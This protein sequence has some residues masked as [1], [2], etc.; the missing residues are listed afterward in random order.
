MT[1]FTKRASYW[2]DSTHLLL[3]HKIWKLSNWLALASILYT[4]DSPSVPHYIFYSDIPSPE[5]KNLCSLTHIFKYNKSLTTMIYLGTHRSQKCAVTHYFCVFSSADT[6]SPDSIL[7]CNFNIQFSDTVQDILGQNE[8]NSLFN[9]GCAPSSETYRSH[10]SDTE[11]HDLAE[12]LCSF[13]T[14]ISSSS[15][16][17]G[18]SRPP[19]KLTTLPVILCDGWQHSRH[20]ITRWDWR[21]I[22]LLWTAISLREGEAWARDEV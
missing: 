4:K 11:W 14:S 15:S 10:F 12:P 21:F 16:S 3:P 8:L 13:P 1:L 7:F 20:Y 19:E 5:P 6:F 18:C 22:G 17:F 2:R 9:Q